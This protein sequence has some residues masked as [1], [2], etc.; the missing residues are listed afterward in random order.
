MKRKLIIR[1]A[2]SLA[3]VIVIATSAAQAQNKTSPSLSHLATQSGAQSDARSYASGRSHA[4][5]LSYAPR[6][7]GRS[8]SRVVEGR[9][10]DIRNNRIV[11]QSSQGSQYDFLIDD[12]TTVLDS[13]EL[14]SIATMDDIGLSVSD[15]RVADHVEIVT[16]RA[17]NRVAARIITR[18]S[19][20]AVASR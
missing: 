9:I 20:G 17:G 18:I 6:V 8:N 4:R 10:L 15:L 13:G 11:I 5:K 1:M 3:I 12:H 14:V 16:E 19:S 2:A 7:I